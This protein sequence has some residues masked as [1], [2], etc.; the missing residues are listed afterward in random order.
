MTNHTDRSHWYLKGRTCGFTAWTCFSCFLTWIASTLTRLLAM[1]HNQISCLIQAHFV[2]YNLSCALAV[3]CRGINKLNT[4]LKIAVS[5]THRCTLLRLPEAFCTV[6]W[7]IWEHWR[8][9][10]CSLQAQS[11]T[12]ILAWMDS[13][14]SRIWVPMFIWV[15]YSSSWELMQLDT[16]I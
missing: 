12:W 16:A 3:F 2:N 8:S 1:K 9:V 6:P 4:H 14:V 7:L 11:S 5:S 13:E 15:Q 10:G